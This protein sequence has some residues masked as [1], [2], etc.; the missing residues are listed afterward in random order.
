MAKNEGSVGKSHRTPFKHWVLNRI[1]GNIAGVVGRRS[2]KFIWGNF[3]VVDLCAG[4][5][6]GGHDGRSSP[7]IIAHHCDWVWNAFRKSGFI[8]G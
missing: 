8:A 4:D 7:E 3:T 5:G 1:L 2:V 6:E